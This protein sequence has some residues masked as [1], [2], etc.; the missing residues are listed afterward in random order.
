M[1]LKRQQATTKL[2]IPRKGK[3]FIARALSH[4][5]NSVP[6][7]IAIR[8]ML[9]LAQNSAEVK[10]MIFNKMLKING[11]VVKD[12]RES[13]QLFNVLE[14]G[15]HY[16]LTLL[17][18]GKFFFEESKDKNQRLCKVV[19]KTLVKNNQIQFSLHDGTNIISKDKIKIG[20]SLHLDFENKIK[21]HIALEKG[22][23]VLIIK[24]KYLGLKG[25]IHSIKDKTAEIQINNHN[26]HLNIN[27]IIVQ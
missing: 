25:K 8:N 10:R 13:L 18:T 6:L 22:K 23:E 24:G 17:P 11:R 21:K 3:K 5:N 7:V 27:Q 14:A 26:T 9:K 12:Y 16:V 2:P 15:K 19:G 20:D 4:T 1:H